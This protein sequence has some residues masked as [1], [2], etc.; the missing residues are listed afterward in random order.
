M[1]LL[2]SDILVDVLRGYLPAVRW[3]EAL[4]KS[5]EVLLPGFVAMELVHGC[6]N[7]AEQRRVE[8]FVDRF[9]VLWPD[10][11]TCQRAFGV[12][13]E[14]HLSRRMGILDAVIGQL[15]VDTGLPLCTF[16]VKHYIGIPDLMTQQPYTK[17]G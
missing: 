14:N 16:N 12:F 7:R 3:L 10:Q 6:R 11:A 9:R 4:E 13:L 17:S 8:G 5:S 15:A 1:L 2:D